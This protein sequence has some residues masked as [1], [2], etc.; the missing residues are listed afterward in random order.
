MVHRILHQL[1]DPLGA[2]TTP[3][4][5]SFS[6]EFK[7]APG[8][9]VV[10]CTNCPLLSRCAPATMVVTRRSPQRRCGRLEAS[11]GP[12]GISAKTLK[13]WKAEHS[14]AKARPCRGL[15]FARYNQ[16]RTFNKRRYA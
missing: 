8:G 2:G 9:A 14:R 5:T 3:L 4:C 12:F 6:F 15:F 13:T 1:A 7:I 11:H 16:A 10:A